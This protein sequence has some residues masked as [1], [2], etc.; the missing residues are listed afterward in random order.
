[1]YV[2]VTR[3]NGKRSVDEHD[4][5]FRLNDFA[6]IRVYQS[7]TFELRSLW[8]LGEAEEGVVTHEGCHNGIIECEGRLPLRLGEQCPSACILPLPSSCNSIGI[9]VA[10]HTHLSFLGVR[11]DPVFFQTEATP[12]SL[13]SLSLSLYIYI[14]IYNFRM[15]KFRK[16]AKRNFFLICTVQDECYRQT[17]HRLTFLFVDYHHYYFEKEGSCPPPPPP[18]HVDVGLTSCLHILELKDI[19]STNVPVRRKYANTE[20][21][22][23]LFILP[24]K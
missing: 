5:A 7:K 9:T 23:G 13:V 20:G 12:L 2:C 22:D 1:M 17:N 15:K 18:L 24:Q 16:Q 10:R 8:L 11:D 4:P 19:S 14:Y 6:P 21:I 3:L